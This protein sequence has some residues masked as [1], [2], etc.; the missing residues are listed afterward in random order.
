MT[1]QPTHV[2]LIEDNQGDA[3]LVRLRL[4]E[5]NSDLEVSCADRLSTGLAA[6]DNAPPAV[7]LLDLNLPDSRG[8]ETFRS[9]LNR[10]PGVPIVVLSA[11]H[12]E[13]LEAQAV[14]HGVQDY[15]IKGTFDGKQLA[16][17]LRYA[18]ERHA[19]SAVKAARDTAL[20]NGRYY[21]KEPVK[22]GTTF[23]CSFCEHSITTLVFNSCNGNRRTQAVAA[24]NRHL[25]L[26]HRDLWKGARSAPGGGNGRVTGE[27][28][29]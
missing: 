15:L 8:A 14:H 29:G 12:D 21:T 22:G 13:A 1:K 23:T 17:V 16:R 26:V 25:S 28:R 20:G 18:I 11:L 7:V 3:D 10:A 27:E 19:A 2:L 24:M 4:V 5:S 6:L 9:V